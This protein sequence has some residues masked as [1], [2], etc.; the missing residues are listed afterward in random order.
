ME[1]LCKYMSMIC[2]KCE[3]KYYI[4]MYNIMFSKLRIWK[5]T[6][7]L[8]FVKVVGTRDECPFENRSYV[9]FPLVGMS[10]WTGIVC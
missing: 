7:H 4:C 10:F 9:V 3:V 1:N 8:N 5:S 2:T 6:F